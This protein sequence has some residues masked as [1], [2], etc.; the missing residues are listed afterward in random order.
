MAQTVRFRLDPEA[1]IL[2]WLPRP[3]EAFAGAK[4]PKRSCA[5]WN[6][7]YAGKEALAALDGGGYKQGSIGTRKYRANIVAWALHHGRWP[8]AM[9]DHDNGIRTDNRPGNLRDVPMLVNGKNVRR[10]PNN[11]SGHTGV[12]WDRATR[13]WRARIVVNRKGI[14]LGQFPTIE[15]AV[16]ARAEANR[17]YGF[18][19]NHGK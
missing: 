18:H 16:T 14:Y 11:T 17:R 19:E 15:E 1:G 5:T 3:V 10:R 7:R 12:E 9:V 13:K 6:G 8:E 2:Y 4:Y